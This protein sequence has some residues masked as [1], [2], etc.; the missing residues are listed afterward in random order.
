MEKKNLQPIELK[1]KEK[2]IS[3]IQDNVLKV[4]IMNPELRSRIYYAGDNLSINSY[5]RAGHPRAL[6]KDQLPLDFDRISGLS[7]CMRVDLQLLVSNDTVVSKCFRC[8]EKNLLT[9][10]TPTGKRYFLYADDRKLFMVF[11]LKC[12]PSHHSSQSFKLK[13]EL[14][15]ETAK[16]AAEVELVTRKRRNPEALVNDDT[17]SLTSPKSPLSPSPG[18][19][20][21]SPKRE[22]KRQATESCAVK[23]TPPFYCPPLVDIRPAEQYDYDVSFANQIMS[24]LEMANHYVEPSTPPPCSSNWS[25]FYPNRV[26]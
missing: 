6:L 10:L 20:P 12:R 15:S 23:I 26:L 14:S 9:L 4:E 5:A 19:P 1:L 18:T 16:Y 8:T 2:R 13:I 21:K 25:F 17:S 11:V 24:I 22:I 7:D 3:N